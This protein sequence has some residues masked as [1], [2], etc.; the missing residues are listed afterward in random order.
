MSVTT[1]PPDAPEARAI[2]H[3]YWREIV[4][5]YNDRAATDDEIQEAD[6]DF[7]SD[8]LLPPTGVFFLATD[9]HGVVG[10]AGLRWADADRAQ[11]ARVFV[12]VRGRGKGWARALL[13]AAERAARASGRGEITAEVRADL[14]EAQALYESHGYERVEPF[15]TAPYADVWL[16]KRLA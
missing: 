14:V 16:R 11:L 3:A 2:L 10:C 1:C 8:D 4:E 6:D 9:P 15:S 13:D 7:P 12:A 5:R